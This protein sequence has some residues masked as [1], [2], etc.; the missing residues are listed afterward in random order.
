MKRFLFVLLSIVISMLMVG[1]NKNVVNEKQIKADLEAYTKKDFFEDGEKIIEITINER[2]TNKEEKL[3]MVWCTV[4]TKDE[5]C[6]YEKSFVLLYSLYDED[7]WMLDN[8]T[9]NNRNE[10]VVTP[11]VGVSDDEITYSLDG[12]NIT[13]NDEIWYVETDN[14]KNVSVEERK[15]N[16][17][18]K[19]DIVTVNV[20]VDD[21]V[22]EANGQLLINYTFKNGKWEIDSVS[23]NEKFTVAEKTGVALN[24]QDE[25]LHD[26]VEGQM[27]TYGTQEIMV[28][29]NEISDFVLQ[30]QEKSS[31]GTIQKYSC[32]CVLTKSYTVFELEIEI[33]YVYSDGM[34]NI[35]P[36]YIIPQCTSVEI[37]GN[38]TGTNVYGRVC[39]LNITEMDAEG[40][41]SGIYSD[42]GDSFNKG[43]SYNVAGQIDLSNLE[44]FLEAGDLI[45]EKPYDRFEPY[46]I[47]ASLMVDDLEI[48]G[49]ADL[50]FFVTQ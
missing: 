21:L 40:N 5:R 42:K 31:K 19:T 44:M 16:L 26:A 8:A 3:D 29:K 30:G 20:T 27:F 18:A 33:L 25:V 1:C 12:V 43:Y 11:L 10:W 38:W 7:G 2:Q 13:V 9:I 46:N 23:G 35:Q 39:E 22:E 15:T 36:I 34:W 24:V 49:N 14:I 32:S 50:K 45:G 17:E 4:L 48:V 28:N 37:E 6:A 47:T 41:I